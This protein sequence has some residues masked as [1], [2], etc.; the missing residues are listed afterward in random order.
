MFPGRAVITAVPDHDRSSPRRFAAIEAGGTKFT[1]G[2]GDGE[3]RLLRQ[4]AFETQGPAQTF[5]E[6]SS[7]LDGEIARSGLVDA[8]GIASF[9]PID[10]DRR[11]ANWGRLGRT[12]KLLWQGVDVIGPFRRYDVPIALDTDVNGAALAEWRWGAAR[13]SDRVC[14][15]TV[16]TGIGGGAVLDGITL[17]GRNHP[18]MG[19]M[20][21]RRHPD[22]AFPGACPIHGDCLEGLASGSAIEA[23]WRGSLSE[24]GAA[25]PGQALIADYLAQA[26][27]NIAVTLAPDVIILGGGVMATPGLFDQ[28][29]DGFDRL[30]NGYL[31]GFSARN[32][33]RAEFYPLS[34]LIGGLAIAEMALRDSQS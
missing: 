11:S 1:V 23:R 3:G 17:S 34:G 7:W 9:G 27:V 21:V 10:V 5:A 28:L 33:L 29:C 15:V 32:I 13:G 14:Y 16:G 31:A 25:S 2:I 18:E 22:D 26:C 24:L 12:P 30:A 4:A 6:V 19:H 8:I 20:F